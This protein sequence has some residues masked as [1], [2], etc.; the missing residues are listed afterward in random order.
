[1]LSAK[2]LEVA[3]VFWLGLCAYGLARAHVHCEYDVKERLTDSRA[4]EILQ[5]MDDVG[6]LVFEPG[7]EGQAVGAHFGQAE[8]TKRSPCPRSF[9]LRKFAMTLIL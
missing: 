1:M 4:I 9:S 3:V 5:I 6:A 8:P 2:A 7:L